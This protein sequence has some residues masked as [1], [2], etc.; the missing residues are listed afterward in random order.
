M[1]NARKP[2]RG[3]G[4]DR[5]NARA[6]LFCALAAA[7]MLMICSTNSFLY[8]VSGWC[9]VDCFVTVARGWIKGLMPYRDLAE[10]KGPLLYFMHIPALLAFPG[11]YHGLWFIELIEMTAALFL[12]WK[13]ARLY[14]PELSVAWVA[15]LG[16]ALCASFAFQMGDSAEEM[17]WPL[18]LGSM[19]GAMRA[20]R[21]GRPLSLRGYVGHG[22]LAGCVLWIKFIQLAPHFVF[23]AMLAILAV[24]EDRSVVRALKMCG[25]FLLGMLIASLPWLICFGVGGAL[26]DMLKMY[27]Y[28]NAFGYSTA[29]SVALD[30]R[31]FFANIGDHIARNRVLSATLGVAIL[32][33]I[34]LKR[35]RMGA[36][37]KVYWLLAFAATVLAIYGGGQKYLYYFFGFAPMTAMALPA[38]EW[39][40]KPARALLE[41]ISAA[42]LRRGAAMALCVCEY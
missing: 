33:V 10:Q 37:E 27:L 41:R 22:V 36:R 19:Y 5:E 20:W 26:G 40:E 38:A 17:C 24:W 4:W 9:D 42:A 31:A 13:M 15:P 7:V 35:E 25:M 14:A 18:I 28:D 39:L 34:T 29:E 21:T 11:S 1:D 23:M 30:A 32:R 3:R 8:P 2:S 16:A 12:S 6:L